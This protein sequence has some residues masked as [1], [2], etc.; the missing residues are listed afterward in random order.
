MSIFSSR[1]RFARQACLIVASLLCLAMSA[2]AFAQQYSRPTSTVTTGN[3]VPVGATP[4]HEA[5]NEAIVS[6][7][8]YIESP[9]SGTAFAEMGL[10]GDPSTITDPNIG[11]GHVL[12]IRMLKAKSGTSGTLLLFQGTTQIASTG[13]LSPAAQNVFEDFTYNLT[14]KWELISPWNL[15]HI[16]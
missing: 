13:T 16:V 15:T 9:E 12:R 14:T 7:S 2:S 4:L 5:V 8:D 6:D 1:A 11:T 3:F 10:S